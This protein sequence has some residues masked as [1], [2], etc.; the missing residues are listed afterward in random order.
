MKCQEFNEAS[1]YL[2]VLENLL[3]KSGKVEKDVLLAE[4]MGL[5]EVNKYL[6]DEN[7]SDNF[8]ADYNYYLSNLI[9]EK[10]VEYE[11]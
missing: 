6:V 2:N 3:L 8:L 5:I 7:S 9:R 1:D 10:G 11:K 4:K